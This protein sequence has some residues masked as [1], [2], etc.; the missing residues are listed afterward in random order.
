[1]PGWVDNIFGPTGAVVAGGAGLLR[2][3]QADKSISAELVP[4]DFTV[5]ALIAS[6]WDVANKKYKW[7][8]FQMT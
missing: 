8:F 6:G 7:K 1:M 3:V 4:A 2:V 5:N